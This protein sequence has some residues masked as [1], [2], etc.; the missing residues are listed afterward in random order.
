[1]NKYVK[2][3][4][5]DRKMLFAFG[6]AFISNGWEDVTKTDDMAD[7]Y[8]VYRL[9]IS[10]L[11]D[12]N[13]AYAY[14]P[15]DVSITGDLGVSWIEAGGARYANDRIAK[16]MIPF[17]YDTLE[18]AEENLLALGIPFQA[19]Y[20]F[21]GNQKTAK[22]RKNDKTRKIWGIDILEEYDDDDEIDEDD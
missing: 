12:D 16:Y 22:K 19:N 5:N 6:D 2:K 17:L 11:D 10:V 1:M 13:Y 4:L 14:L 3:A 7:D 20:E 9:R 18:L 15:K 21:T 8:R